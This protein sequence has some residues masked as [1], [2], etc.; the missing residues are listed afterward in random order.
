[1]A[2]A[3]DQYIPLSLA[4]HTFPAFLDV[5]LTVNPIAV[6]IMTKDL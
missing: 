3:F 5:F 4:N 1:M 6:K 2:F